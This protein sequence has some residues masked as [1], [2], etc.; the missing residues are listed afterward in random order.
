MPQWKSRDHR[1][2]DHGECNAAYGWMQRCAAD[3]EEKVFIQQSTDLSLFSPASDCLASVIQCPKLRRLQVRDCSMTDLLSL[4][5]QHSGWGQLRELSLTPFHD[6]LNLPAADVIAGFF[7]L[8]S[9][10]VMTL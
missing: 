3:A 4:W 9:L 1:G 8:R 5:S 2:V 10:V 6:R 7:Y